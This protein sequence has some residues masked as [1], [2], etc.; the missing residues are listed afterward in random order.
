[1]H[2]T[3]EVLQ[4]KGPLHVCIELDTASTV[5][6]SF[7]LDCY[8]LLLFFALCSDRFSEDRVY[9]ENEGVVAYTSGQDI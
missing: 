5:N 6:L 3:L 1:M 4:A 2:S 8:S 7:G 9:T